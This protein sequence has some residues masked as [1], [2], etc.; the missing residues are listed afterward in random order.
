MRME[1]IKCAARYILIWMIDVILFFEQKLSRYKDHLIYYGLL[2]LLLVGLFRCTYRNGYID[3]ENAAQER[4]EVV[5]RVV[6]NI[7]HDTIRIVEPKYVT[8]TYNRTV[9]DTFYIPQEDTFIFAEVPI[10]QLYYRQDSLY[11]AWISGYNSNL[12]S[13]KIFP[14]TICQTERILIK[15]KRKPWGIGLS[16]GYGITGS[17]IGIGIQYNVLQW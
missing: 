8:K 10:D 7:V 14:K 15:Q 3:G 11:E 12:D 4:Y 9:I 2:F 5:E 6:T 1:W 16:A 13:I 17:Y